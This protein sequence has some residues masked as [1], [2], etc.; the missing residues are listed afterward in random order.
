MNIHYHYDK[1]TESERSFVDEAI[2]DVIFL[3][4]V[5]RNDLFIKLAGDDRAEAA[6]DALA[7]WVIES[8]PSEDAF[9]ERLCNL[10]SQMKEHEDTFR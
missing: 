4:K 10:N 5:A 8:R 6:A 2:E 9:A 1:L 3:G 7:K